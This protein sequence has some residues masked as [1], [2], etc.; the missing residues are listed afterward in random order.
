MSYQQ[1]VVVGNIGADPV[2]RYLE[3]GRAVCNFSVAVTERWKDRQSNEPQ[4]RTTW[5]RI[6]AWGQLAE[7]CNTYLS[8][9]R[10]VMAVGNVV[11]RAYTDKNGEPAASLDL[12]AQR[13]IFLG[14]GNGNG[15]T[16]DGA[17]ETDASRA[18]DAIPF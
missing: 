9:G 3:N 17:T 13:V 14:N 10:Q 5:Y 8:K 18:L 16:P 6:A 11:A 7:T 4:E 1:T 12:T 15:S 2:L